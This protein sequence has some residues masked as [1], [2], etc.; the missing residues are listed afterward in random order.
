MINSFLSKSDFWEENFDFERVTPLFDKLGLRWDHN[1]MSDEHR[2]LPAKS[3][4]MTVGYGQGGRVLGAKLP[5]KALPLLSFEGD[6]LGFVVKVGKGKL[7]VLGDAG[8]VSNGLYHFPGFDNARFILKLFEDMTPAWGEGPAGS[9]IFFEFGHLSCATSGQG[10]SEKIFK[11]LRP[12]AKFVSDHHYRHLSHENNP[13][14]I[15]SADA[16][17]KLPVKIENIAGKRRVTAGFSYVNISG[18]A[19]TASFEMELN[20]SEKKSEIGADY[21]ISGAA[22]NDSLKWGDI[23]ANPAVFNEIGSLI[24]VNTVVQIF[25][26]ATPDGCLRYFT[27]RQGQTLYIKNAGNIHYG[28]DILLGS[29]NITVSPTA[30]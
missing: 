10:I 11:A 16:V 30:D 25:I 23:G 1:F 21:T 5:D 20:V 27:M 9:F 29:K 17:G 6:A 14:T 15:S 2:I 12:G 13:E 22:V 24:R 7:A 28:V 3:E 19:D 18:G 8:L 26:G 4:D